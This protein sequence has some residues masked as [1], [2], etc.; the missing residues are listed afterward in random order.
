LD[1]GRLAV[2]GMW[3]MITS[4]PAFLVLASIL[5]AYAQFGTRTYLYVIPW[6][7]RAERKCE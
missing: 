7:F 3:Y 5:D 2:E 4:V 1:E 6:I